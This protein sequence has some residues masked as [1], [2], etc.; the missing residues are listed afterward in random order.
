VP[1]AADRR[2]CD[3]EA[4]PPRQPA[5]KLVQ[6]ERLPPV[7]TLHLKRFS[8]GGGRGAA[9]VSAKVPFPLELQ[10]GP[11]CSAQA[12]PESLSDLG[13]PGGGGARYELSGVVEHQGSLSGGHYT[14][15]VRAGS[16]WYHMSDS[17]V[18]E[19]DEEAVL[20]AQASLLFYVQV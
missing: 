7:L 5:V 13:S 16:S 12:P 3:A 20:G 6:L 10:L 15:F 11:Y 1:S 14:A 19:A 17:H 4:R 9:K 2:A 8:A 18:S